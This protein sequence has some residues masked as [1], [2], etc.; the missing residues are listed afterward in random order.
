MCFFGVYVEVF[1]ILKKYFYVEHPTKGK[2]L[3]GLFPF[4]E[5]TLL[6]L[7]NDNLVDYVALDF[8][9]T[10][11]KFKS[12]TDTNLFN[13]FKDTLSFLIKKS[14][15][16]E[17]RT[18]IHSH[19]FDSS[20]LQQM[21]SFLEKINYKGIYYLQKFRNNSKTIERDEGG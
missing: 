20:D 17:V 18:T 14:I 8:K 1:E 5:T 3:F 2:I 19:L 6:D 12:I 10:P 16:H 9:A 21:V 4:Q 7:I 13:E 11:E 15:P